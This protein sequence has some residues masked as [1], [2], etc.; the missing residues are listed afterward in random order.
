MDHLAKLSTG[1]GVLGA[2]AVALVTAACGAAT[3]PATQAQP[4]QPLAANAAATPRTGAAADDH[5]VLTHRHQ[6][7]ALLRRGLTATERQ[8]ST[9]SGRQH[10]HRPLTRSRSVDRG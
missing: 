8:T 2:L 9:N 5:H 4:A 1:A 6:R 10:A 3:A 7:A